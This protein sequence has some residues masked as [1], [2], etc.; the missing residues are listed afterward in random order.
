MTSRATMTGCGHGDLEEAGKALG[1]LLQGLACARAASVGIV[2]HTLD[3]KGHLE[4]TV[5]EC[6]HTLP[7]V[8]SFSCLVR[9]ELVDGYSYANI[10][11]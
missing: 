11:L 1:S 6:P 10:S 8:C 9:A 7:S 5:P 2:S 4:A 3:S